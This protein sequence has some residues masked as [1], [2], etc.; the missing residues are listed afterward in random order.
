MLT[1]SSPRSRIAVQASGAEGRGA[2]AV[3]GGRN[4][5]PYLGVDPSQL[6]RLGE[7]GQGPVDLHQELRVLGPDRQGHVPA[8]AGHVLAH[9]PQPELGWPCRYQ[10]AKSASRNAASSDAVAEPVEQLLARLEP[11]DDMVLLREGHRA[12]HDPDPFRRGGRPGSEPRARLAGTTSPNWAAGIGNAPGHV[13]RGPEPSGLAD[14]DIAA[15]FGQAIQEHSALAHQW[16]STGRPRRGPPAPRRRRRG[17]AACRPAPCR[18]AASRRARRR[19]STVFGGAVGALARG[20]PPRT[21]PEE[22]CGEAVSTMTGQPTPR[23]SLAF[24]LIRNLSCGGTTQ[25]RTRSHRPRSVSFLS[26]GSAKTNR[27][28]PRRA[29]RSQGRRRR[30]SRPSSRPSRRRRR[31]TA[32]RRGCR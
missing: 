6:A 7:L 28:L 24:S 11:R 10:A 3:K 12:G 21:D 18:S 2:D 19:R 32:G 20:S 26:S 17:P 25:N 14:D 27:V 23:P 1:T 22:Q 29:F 16:N 4:G 5:T 13:A 9:E 30:R 8:L 15:A 31:C